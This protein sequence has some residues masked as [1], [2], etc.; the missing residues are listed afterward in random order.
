MLV[1]VKVVRFI[2]ADVFLRTSDN[3]KR[4]W[5]VSIDSELN[6]TRYF[7]AVEYIVP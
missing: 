4:I 1:L 5:T 7:E 2:E 3:R 6:F